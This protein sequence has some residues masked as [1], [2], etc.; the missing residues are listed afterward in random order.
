MDVN[1]FLGGSQ[2]F[3]SRPGVTYNGGRASNMGHYA[4]F[5]DGNNGFLIYSMKGTGAD[6][7]LMVRKKSNTDTTWSDRVELY[8]SGNLDT[9]TFASKTSVDAKADKTYVDNALSL[10]A[11]ISTVSAKADKTYVDSA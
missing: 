3:F 11:N 7:N 2:A 6:I 10:K 4:T 1:S 8:H 9:S 5:T